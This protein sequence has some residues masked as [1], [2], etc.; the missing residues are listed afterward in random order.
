[1]HPSADVPKL[2]HSALA[3]I[4]GVAH[5]AKGDVKR[6]DIIYPGSLLLLAATSDTMAHGQS[7]QILLGMAVDTSSKHDLIT[8]AWYLPEMGPIE[9]YRGGGKRRTLDLFGRWMPVDG[10]S[11]EALKDCH[12]PS[13]IVHA[14]SVL[15]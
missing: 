12:L 1:M 10:L 4:D 9:N 15:E 7:R 11:I 14:R 2:P 6:S 8:V 5:A 13:P 3:R